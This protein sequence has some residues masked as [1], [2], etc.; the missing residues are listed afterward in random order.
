M[1]FAPSAAGESSWCFRG[2]LSPSSEMRSYDSAG[3]VKLPIHF[4][5]DA[6]TAADIAGRASGGGA[7]EYTEQD[8][9][10][11]ASGA[12]VLCCGIGAPAAGGA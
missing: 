8:A 12:T 3:E 2:A 6:A 1:V 5:V 4:E 7:N 9:R 10:D 11:G